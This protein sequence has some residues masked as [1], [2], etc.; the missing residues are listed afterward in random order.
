M[1]STTATVLALALIGGAYVLLGNRGVTIDLYGA[2]ADPTV[3]QLE[4]TLSLLKEKFPNTIRNVRFHFVAETNGGKLQSYLLTGLD[5]PTDEQ[6]ALAKLDLDEAGRE[7]WIQAHYPK[8]LAKYLAL[9]NTDFIGGSPA[10]AAVYANIPLDKLQA[11]ITSGDAEKLL[12]QESTNLKNVRTKLDPRLNLLPYLLFNGELYRGR[13]DVMSLST[14]VAK[15]VLRHGREAL[16][17]KRPLSLFGGRLS[18]A[19]FRTYLVNNIPE[20][21][22]DAD[23]QDNPQKNGHLEAAGTNFAH[24]VYQT[25]AA[26]HLSV[27][28]MDKNYKTEKDGLLFN[29]Q[30][31]VKGLEAKAVSLDDTTKDDLAKTIKG[32]G[33]NDKLSDLATAPYYIFEPDLAKDAL[34]QLYQQAKLVFPL[35]DGRFLLNRLAL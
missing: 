13:A 3:L 23:C 17:E 18:I 11:A 21:Y 10:F 29:I 24:C 35:P 30:Q 7:L 25:P 5:K 22:T 26:V 28:T 8:N 1:I 15:L 34:F 33:L 9:R 6:Q 4:N 16:P 14:Q 31:D 12:I 27:L 20:A 19:P 32:L 2:A